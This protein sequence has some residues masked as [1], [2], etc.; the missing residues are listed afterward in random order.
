MDKE[1]N[2]DADT[3]DICI[4]INNILINNHF[5]KFYFL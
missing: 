3:L 5:I 1:K 4:K 2:M